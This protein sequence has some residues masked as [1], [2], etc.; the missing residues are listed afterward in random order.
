[1]KKKQKSEQLEEKWN[2]VRGSILLQISKTTEI[3]AI[4]LVTKKAMLLFVF[5]II[6]IFTSQGQI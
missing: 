2:E 6:K 4:I 3:Q 1:M 5:F